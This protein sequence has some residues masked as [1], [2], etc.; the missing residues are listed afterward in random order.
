MSTVAT[1]HPFLYLGQEEA[2]WEEDN[3]TV[4]SI[5][6]AVTI[7]RSNVTEFAM[8]NNA[9]AQCL[10]RFG[11]EAVRMMLLENFLVRCVRRSTGVTPEEMTD[12]AIIREAQEFVARQ[13]RPAEIPIELDS[14]GG[15]QANGDAVGID[16]GNVYGATVGSFSISAGGRFLESAGGSFPVS[17]VGSFPTSAGGDQA[18]VSSLSHSLPQ[19]A[20]DQVSVNANSDDNG[21]NRPLSAAAQAQNDETDTNAPN[22]PSVNTRKRKEKGIDRSSD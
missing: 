3:K 10:Q 9:V 14:L 16:L 15:G 13:Q 11:A 12:E 2:E 8:A 4:K 5:H 21:S 1:N 17:A 18:S 20:Q 7:H 19:E 22:Q 6:S